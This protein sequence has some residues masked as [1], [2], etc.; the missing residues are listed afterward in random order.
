MAVEAAHIKYVAPNQGPAYWQMGA[1]LVTFLATGEDTQGRYALFEVRDEPH[2]GPPMHRHTRE[3][4]AYFILEGEYEVHHPGAAPLRLLPGAF[5]HVPRGAVGTY[6]CVSDQGGRMLVL[7][8]PSGGE[9]F[10]AELG[11]LAQDRHNRPTGGPAPDPAEV[12]AIAA[13]HG[14]EVVGPPV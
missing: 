3:D 14:I 12:A 1:A 4:E 6:K 13:R 2:S 8:S 7:L 5:V 9:Q 11:Q 10:F